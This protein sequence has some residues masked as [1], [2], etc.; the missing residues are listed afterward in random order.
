MRER[1][2][3]GDHLGFLAQRYE[4][5]RIGMSANARKAARNHVLGLGRSAAVGAE[6]L[7]DRFGHERLRVGAGPATA[8]AGSFVPIAMSSQWAWGAGGS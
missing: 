2:R 6:N 1:P 5:R 4:D 3:L 8:F 7:G